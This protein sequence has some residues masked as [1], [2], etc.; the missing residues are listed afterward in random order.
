MKMNLNLFDRI[1]RFILGFFLT[2]WLIAG[3]P[4]WSSL[5]LYLM[6]TAGWGFCPLY[7]LLKIR[8][9]KIPSENRET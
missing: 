9:L 6:M 3:G 2:I 7:S 8:T 5:G 4:G 1:L